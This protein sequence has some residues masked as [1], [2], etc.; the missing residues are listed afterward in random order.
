MSVEIPHHMYGTWIGDCGL[1]DDVPQQALKHLTLWARENGGLPCKT[2]SP[3]KAV[4]IAIDLWR[5]SL[6]LIGVP[7]VMRSCAYYPTR[8]SR[9]KASMQVS[10]SQSRLF[11][12]IELYSLHNLS[13]VDGV[14]F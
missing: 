1:I 2:A 11:T 13:I 5:G 14:N 6:S 12:K 8:R 4:R 7:K 9:V 10:P 3:L